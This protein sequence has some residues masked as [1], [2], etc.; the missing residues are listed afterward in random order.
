MNAWK[1]GFID[2]LRPEKPLTV[3]EWADEYR[4]LS[5]KASSEPG[6]WRT[7]RT[8]Y[9]QQCMDVLSSSSQIQRVVMMFAAQT[10]KTEAGS[11]WLGY[12][13]HH[14]PG[15]LLAVQPTVEMAKRLSKQRLESMLSE[16]PCLAKRIAPAR[17]RDSGNTMFQKDFVGGMM[18]LTGANSATGLR[19][20]PCRYIFC[21]E[22]DAFPTDCGEGDPV[23]LAEKRATTF[24]RRKVLLTST[25]TIKDF[26]RIEAEYL[27]SDQR[28]YFVPMPCCGVMD[29][30]KWPQIKYDDEVVEYEC[31]HCGERFPETHKTS[32]LRQG[33]WRP[34][35]KGDGK[36]AG[37]WL[38]GLNSPLGWFSWDE[39]VAEFKKAKGDAPLLKSW[40]NTRLAETWEEDYVS[41]ISA[42]GLLK[43]CEPYTPG[44]IPEGVLCITQGVDCQVDRLEVSIWGWGEGEEGWLID[45][46]VLYGDPHQK[47]VWE[48]L[49]VLVMAEYEVPEPGDKEHLVKL[50]PECTAIDSGGLHTSEVY[51]YT[52]ERQSMNC[53][54][55]KG[56]SQRNKPPIGKPTRVD[57]NVR[58]RTLKKG[59]A[60]YPVGPD[61]IKSTLMGRLKHN[62][63]GPGYLHFHAQTGEEYF[64]QLTAERQQLR[65]NRSGFQIPEWVKKPGARNEALDCLVYAYS[66]LNFLYQRYPRGKVW[67]ILTNRLLNPVNSSKKSRLKSRQASN[68]K[69]YVNNW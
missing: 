52:R 22:V 58:G 10:G 17:A 5:S 35:A 29:Y 3:S 45:H 57:V 27:A 34:T 4:M 36:T 37:F 38:N 16:T 54:A 53:L 55:I 43:R 44:S 7:S 30:L 32:M 50:K 61:T 62:D 26:S 42:E 12:V 13:I 59:A 20:T 60:V 40:V 67:Q 46:Q 18:L 56:S 23:S 47:T 8:P 2:G 19:S 21:D 48:Q 63:P 31:E 69:S 41:K 49:D 39:L 14:A 33:E 25:P 68:K 51:A 9:L 64:Q 1:E 66:S 24:A 6:R 28:K 11:N 15:P 65:T